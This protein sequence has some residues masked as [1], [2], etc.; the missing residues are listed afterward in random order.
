MKEALLLV[1]LVCTWMVDA[2]TTSRNGSR[3][4]QVL[5]L[6]ITKVVMLQKR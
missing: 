2:Q 4:Y 1:I 5:K 6:F 3:M